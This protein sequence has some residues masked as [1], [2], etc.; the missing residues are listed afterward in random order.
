[1]HLGKFLAIGTSFLQVKANANDLKH[2][3][4]LLNMPLMH[5]CMGD[6]VCTLLS[7]S[8]SMLPDIIDVPAEENYVEVNHVWLFGKEV[9][10]RGHQD[11]PQLAVDPNSRFKTNMYNT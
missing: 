3:C 7:S 8:E 9:Q 1:M 6:A 2:S 5:P 4:G 11:T 10:A